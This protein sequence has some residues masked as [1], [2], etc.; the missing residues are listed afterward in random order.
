[1]FK[2]KRLIS[3]L[4]IWQPHLPEL[5]FNFNDGDGMKL[6][7]PSSFHFG[8]DSNSLHQLYYDYWAS[9]MKIL[10]LSCFQRSTSPHASPILQ[11]F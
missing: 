3:T 8:T 2:K 4:R 10:Q 9:A 6:P 5:M 7:K 11:G 1:V